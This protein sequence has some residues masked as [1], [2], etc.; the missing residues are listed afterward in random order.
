[1]WSLFASALMAAGPPNIGTID[2]FGLDRIPES[3]LREQLGFQEGDL[4]PPSKAAVEER[5]ESLDGVV[6]ARVTAL[7]CEDGA[8]TLFIGIEEKG[9]P[10]F[11]LLPEPSAAVS[12]PEELMEAYRGFLNA[13][14]RS[15]R[16]H[17]VPE[18]RGPGDAPTANAEVRGYQQRFAEQARSGYALIRDVL[19]GASDPDARAAAALLAGYASDRKAAA[20]D[21]Q[22]ALR[23]PD[24][25]VRQNALRSLGDIA[26]YSQR[27]PEAGVRIPPTWP[28]EMLPSVQWSDRTGAVDLLLKLTETRDAATLQQIRERAL[29]PLA[30]MARWKSRPHALRACLLLG[31]VAGMNDKEIEEAWTSG[32]RGKIIAAAKASARRR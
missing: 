21:L 5:L 9:A 1:M 23:D 29:A 31:R 25:G 4:L 16:A 20:G 27:H 24:E 30:E 6:Q 32:D 12:L 8:V 3:R 10:H 28:I 13:L 17:G 11:T 26:L 22:H 14:E 2:F 19:R 18:D 7:C 15:A